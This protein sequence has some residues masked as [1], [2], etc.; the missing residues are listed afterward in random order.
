MNWRKFTPAVFFALFLIM[1]F[2]VFGILYFEVENP[3][4]NVLP[5]LIGFGL[6]GAFF[7]V[8]FTYLQERE[9]KKRTIQRRLELKQTLDNY[10][11]SI[12]LKAWCLY[13]YGIDDPTRLIPEFDQGSFWERMMREMEKKVVLSSEYQKEF[14]SMLV[15]RCNVL[16]T[17]CSVNAEL[18]DQYVWAWSNILY[19]VQHI[20]DHGERA[21]T[22]QDISNLLLAFRDFAIIDPA[23]KT[24]DDLLK[25]LGYITLYGEKS[26]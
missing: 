7:V 5:E 19:N 25:K 14:Y 21:L 10:L 17:L 24:T 22:R 8:L 15:I 13:P 6:E 9:S 26:K 3:W 20:V 11:D 23:P 18:G 1:A 12:L 4:E 2:L 16:H